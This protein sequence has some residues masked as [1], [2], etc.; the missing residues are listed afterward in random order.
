[1][2]M[3]V[4]AVTLTCLSALPSEP[5]LFGDWAE[6][7]NT[8]TIAG[9]R[10]RHAV[11]GPDDGVGGSGPDDGFGGSGGGGRIVDAGQS[12]PRDHNL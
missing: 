11:H 3:T 7:G 1:M 12:R 10:R 8:G 4:G 2:C 9:H 5:I 6:C